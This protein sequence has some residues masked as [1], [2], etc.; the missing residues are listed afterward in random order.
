MTGQSIRLGGLGLALLA[1]LGAGPA[2]A[3]LPL[4]VGLYQNLPKVGWT[5]DGRPAGIFVDLLDEIAQKENWTIQY[6]RGT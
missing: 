3:D 4:R 1:L 2:V 5:E 6:V